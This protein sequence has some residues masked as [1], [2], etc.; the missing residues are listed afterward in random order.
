MKNQEGLTPNQEIKTENNA[1]KVEKRELSVEQFAEI[2]CRNGQ[3]LECSE[4]KLS[5]LGEYSFTSGLYDVSINSVRKENFVENPEGVYL[6]NGDLY[7]VKFQ[8]KILNE[9][10]SQSKNVITCQYKLT[11]VGV[12]KLETPSK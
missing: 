5:M 8:A 7:A 11:P 9:Y 6:F 4:S 2:I 10:H 3:L 1:E 12:E